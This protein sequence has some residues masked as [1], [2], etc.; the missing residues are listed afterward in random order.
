MEKINRM[1]I[2]TLILALSIAFLG[3]QKADN[4]NKVNNSDEIPS[5]SQM[6]SQPEVL[7]TKSIELVAVGDDLLHDVII[8][9]SQ[10]SDGSYNFD[11]L[12]S[13]VKEDIQAADIAII[14]QETILGGKELGYSGYP[15]FNSPQEVGD[16]IIRTGFNVVLHATNHSMDRGYK[17][18]KN[19]IEYW[20]TH[21]D[22]LMLGI[23]DSKEN[24]EKIGVIE[25]NGIKVAI[26]NY[27][28]GL[29]GIP[30][31]SDKPYLVNL[32]EKEVMARHIEKAKAIA[33][34]VIVTPHWGTEYVHKPDDLQE[35]L[36][37]FFADQGVDIV[38][39]TH[40]HVIQPI[41]WI[42]SKD[43]K[44]ML[45]Y[46]S[47]G[48]FVSCQ[49]KSPRML[50]GMAKITIEK[51]GSAVSISDAGITPLVTHYESSSNWNFTVYKLSDYTSAKANKHGI[52]RSNNSFSA[53]MLNGLAMQ[54]FG[55]WIEQ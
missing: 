42:D 49:D 46:Y 5:N 31:P 47:L 48:N 44:K 36:T 45:V 30:L 24:Q 33:D 54:V 22:I 13:G 35:D 2:F 25:K 27:T 40:P 4:Q 1:F 12:F 34:L 28:Y 3:C 32:L 6:S 23:N 38:I 7:V 39:G 53:D 15:C 18:I 52:K 9:S 14:N 21:S 51:T 50:G 11:N 8:K 43:N 16:A 17:A 20:K 10:K 19:T 26:L 29:N 37:N 55:D 41:K